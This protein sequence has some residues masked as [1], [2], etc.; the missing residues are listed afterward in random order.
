M[1]V[2]T[3]LWTRNFTLIVVGTIIS[4]IAGQVITIPLSLAVFD[5]TQSTFLSGLLMVMAFIPNTIVPIIIAPIIDNNPKKRVIVGLDYLQSVLYI[6]MGFYLKMHAFNYP[7][8][9]VMTLFMG[10]ISSVYQLAY[11]AW[12]PD[13]IS[14]GNEQKGFAVSSSIYPSVMI[15]FAPV[16]TFLYATIQL[17]QIFFIV[18]ALLFTAATFEILIKEEVKERHKKEFSFVEYKSDL[19]EGFRFIKR[20]KGIR[21]IYTYM[22]ITNGISGPLMML[23]QAY[24]QTAT[25]LTV[26][27]Y[28]FL[29]SVGTVGRLLGGLIQ[30]RKEIEPKKRYDVTKYVYLTY[31]T[32]D[33]IL[34]FLPYPLM[35]V[36]R[37][38]CGALGMTS[39]TLRETAVQSYLP[40][41]MRAKV[42][43]VFLAYVSICV[44]VFQLLIG[45]SGD[46]LGHRTTMVIFAG[47]TL[48]MVYIFIIRPQAENRKVYEATRE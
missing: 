27:M 34:L 42:N 24:F 35:L 32:M 40:E 4:A 13:L 25:A 45:I 20:E 48:C 28:G 17:Y 18:S 29:T 37:F 15:I 31:E 33:M 19:L 43:A 30:Y 8:F 46:Y 3:T 12:Y 38:I 14:K 1:F 5:E 6:A 26:T 9:L 10:F 2:K 21:S 39:A 16:A 23:T 44:I 22:G 47:F 41:H 7:L 36:N 11:R